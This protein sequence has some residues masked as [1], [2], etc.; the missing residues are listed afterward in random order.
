M[1]RIVSEHS[2]DSISSCRKQPSSRPQQSGGVN[3]R[4]SF[5]TNTLV[6]LSSV[7]S[8]FRKTTSSQP[9]AA[10]RA[11]S[12]SKGSRQFVLWRRST[13]PLET[14]N[15]GSPDKCR[16]HR[17]ARAR[18]GNGLCIPLHSIRAARAR[19][20]RAQ[21]CSARQISEPDR[22]Q[23]FGRVEHTEPK[24]GDQ[25]VAWRPGHKTRLQKIAELVRELACNV[26]PAPQRLL[27][28]AKRRC[29]FVW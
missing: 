21:R 16:P 18:C 4:S 19:Q 9:N 10:A 6:R 8:P 2:R 29:D 17:S 5:R 24:E 7:I 22:P 23:N 3:I 1:H 26:S 11:C 28:A 13:S 20:M 15:S 25:T 27:R 12:S 14:R